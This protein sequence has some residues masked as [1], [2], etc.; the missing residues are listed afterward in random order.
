MLVATVAG[1]QTVAPEFAHGVHYTFERIE[2]E[3][4]V[5]DAF[6]QGRITLVTFVY[7]PVNVAQRGVIGC[8][9]GSTGGWT[10]SPREPVRPPRALVQYFTSR[11]YTVVAPL[12]RGGTSSRFDLPRDA[13]GR[14]DEATRRSIGATSANVVV[15]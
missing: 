6:D 9:H 8:S 12:R 3:R 10:G 14:R 4:I 11:G 13:V 2:A 15:A 7:R 5:D 1:S